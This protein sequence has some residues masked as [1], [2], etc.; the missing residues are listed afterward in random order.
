M[1]RRKFILGVGGV[2]V[3]SAGVIGTGAFSNITADRDVTLRIAADNNGYLEFDP[4]SEL[5]TIP[6]GGVTE[7]DLT[8]FNEIPDVDGKG[9]NKRSVFEITG[10]S[11]DQYEGVFALRNQ[12][13][14]QIEFAS[15]TVGD[16]NEIEK[17]NDPG[18]LDFNALS[19]SDPRIELFE[20]D[21]SNRTAI[22]DD[23][24]VELDI[25]FQTALGFRLIVPEV[26]DLGSHTIHQIIV[27]RES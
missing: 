4:V 25:G 17:P 24:W 13:D 18:E 15:T 7:F 20:I 27:A 22:D 3:G 23:N 19:E 1:N 14:R 10:T 9:F 8:Q 5:T 2:S 26:A 12:A 11:R 6:H 16:I 21:D